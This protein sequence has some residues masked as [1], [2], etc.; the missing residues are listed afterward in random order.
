VTQLRR[1]AYTAPN[2]SVSAGSLFLDYFDGE[3][4]SIM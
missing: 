1:M 3:V 2:V 4:S